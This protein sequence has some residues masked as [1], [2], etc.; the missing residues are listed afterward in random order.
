[1]EGAED[2]V[3]IPPS[4]GP[5][6][7]LDD[8]EAGAP[9]PLPGAEWGGIGGDSLSRRRGESQL[10]PEQSQAESVEVA[11]MEGCESTM[12]MRGLVELCVAMGTVEILESTDKSNDY[13]QYT[14]FL[15]AHHALCP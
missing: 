14:P 7:L 4:S 12:F 11:G 5:Y 15:G 13:G 10:S 9:Q 2:V 6:Q 3:P 1:M 8:D